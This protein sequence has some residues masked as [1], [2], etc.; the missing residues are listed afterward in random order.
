MQSKGRPA[1]VVGRDGLAGSRGSAVSSVQSLP[2]VEVDA[3]FAQV[4]GLTEGMKVHDL[5]FPTH[6]PRGLTA[7]GWN[8]SSCRSTPGAY[9][10]HRAIDFGRLG[11]D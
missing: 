2:T 1:P 5:N 10:Q 9:H 6:E 3:T 8:N 4:V 11:D 7:K